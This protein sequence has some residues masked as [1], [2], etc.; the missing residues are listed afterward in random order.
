MPIPSGTK[1]ALPM[2]QI[3]TRKDLFYKTA[4]PSSQQ[5]QSPGWNQPD[6]SVQFLY[7]FIKWII[8][9]N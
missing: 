9:L 2:M 4:L 1:L 7:N 5:E 3:Y 6:N 8:R